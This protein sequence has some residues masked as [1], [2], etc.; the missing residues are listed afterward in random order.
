M[1]LCLAL[2][3]LPAFAD[4][5]PA[6]TDLSPVSWLGGE[7]GGEGDGG[8]TFEEHWSTPRDGAMMG[9]FRL[10]SGGQVRVYEFLLLELEEGSIMLRLRH[11]RSAMKDVDE[12]PLRLKLAEAK[13]GRLVFENPDGDRPKRIIYEKDGEKGLNATVE[14]TR[15]G[16]PV[17][18]TLKMIKRD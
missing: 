8:M 13:D 2:F 5:P 11:Y 1:S 18:F 3:T 15:E 4:D 16:Q 17:A 6:Y 14:T 9:M 10:A 7:F 12:A